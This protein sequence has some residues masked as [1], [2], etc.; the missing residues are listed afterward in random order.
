MF[1]LS[2]LSKKSFIAAI[3][4]LLLAYGVDSLPTRNRV[5]YLGIDPVLWDYYPPYANN[6]ALNGGSAGDLCSNGPFET[7]QLLFVGDG[8]S[9]GSFTPTSVYQKLKFQEYTDSSFTTKVTRTKD[10]DHLAL[11]GPIIR[12]EVQDT[13]TVYLRGVPS[14][15]P[16]ATSYGLLI[17]SL[18]VSGGPATV[19]PG[20]VKQ[21]T[22]SVPTQAGS[23]GYVSSRLLLYR[24][25]VDGNAD[26][27]RGVYQGLIGPL[28][29][30]S[31]N[32]LNRNGKPKAVSKELVTVLWVAN[33]NK[34]GESGDEEESNLMHGING[35]VFCSLE[36]LD[37]TVGEKARWYF[38]T[39]GNEVRLILILFIM[40]GWTRMI[41]FFFLP[42]LFIYNYCL[43]VFLFFSMHHVY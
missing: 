8:T 26:G 35:R 11:L 1:S 33:E 34:G 37:L 16:G 27:G 25:I 7:S 29:V 41:S 40:W 2:K 32:A 5:I 39:V 24:G 4:F 17:D 31:R 13:I 43:F 9:W 42:F 18:A 20:K 38:A 14:D 23:T 10:E 30:Y 19:E 22:F 28:I 15:T 6:R 21:F 12:A 3:S 36:G